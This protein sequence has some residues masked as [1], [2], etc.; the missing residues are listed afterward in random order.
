MFNEPAEKQDAQFSGDGE[1]T[2]QVSEDDESESSVSD[3]WV[4][5]QGAESP[6]DTSGTV[7][8]PERMEGEATNG[9]ASEKIDETGD[10]WV[11]FAAD[12]PVA[13]PTEMTFLRITISALMAP[14]GPRTKKTKKQ[15]ISKTTRTKHG[16]QRPPR[17]SI[18]KI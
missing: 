4:P 2:S 7:V 9:Q 13:E 12:A 11:P 3:T 6:P 1:D 16:F 10:T 18:P 15:R 17:R 14:T 8:M 5:G